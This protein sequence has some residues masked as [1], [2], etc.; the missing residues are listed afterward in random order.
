MNRVI[1][2]P[3][4]LKNVLFPIGDSSKFPTSSDPLRFSHQVEKNKERKQKGLR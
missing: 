1:L 3:D 4:F 2:S